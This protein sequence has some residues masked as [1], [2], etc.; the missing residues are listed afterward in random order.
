MKR[1]RSD[2]L[3]KTG[4]PSEPHRHQPSHSP[5]SIAMRKSAVP[6]NKCVVPN[7]SAERATITGSPKANGSGRSRPVQYCLDHYR[8][9]SDTVNGLEGLSSLVPIPLERKTSDMSDV[10]S[11]GGPLIGTPSMSPTTIAATLAFDFDSNTMS[12]HRSAS[13]ASDASGGDFHVSLHHNTGITPS[14][15]SVSEAFSSLLAAVDMAPAPSPIMSPATSPPTSRFGSLSSFGHPRLGGGKQFPSQLKN[16]G[17]PVFSPPLPRGRKRPDN[18]DVH[19]HLQRLNISGRKSPA[20]IDVELANTGI[21]GHRPIVQVNA[22]NGFP[23]GMQVEN[24]NGMKNGVVKATLVKNAS[25]SP[26]HIEAVQAKPVDLK[27]LDVNPDSIIRV[28]PTNMLTASGKSP[29]KQGGM[30]SGSSHTSPSKEE[31]DSYHDGQTELPR[32][33]TV[34]EHKAAK[35]KYKTYMSPDGKRFRS[36]LRARNYVQELEKQAAKEAAEAA[37]KGTPV[38]ATSSTG[39]TASAAFRVGG[40][41]HHTTQSNNSNNS[42][43]ETASDGQLGVFGGAATLATLSSEE[44]SNETTLFEH[45]VGFV[46]SAT[47]TDRKV[48]M[49][50]Y[51]P[52]HGETVVFTHPSCVSP[53]SASPAAPHP[54]ASLESLARIQS[55]LLSL[56]NTSS[57]SWRVPHV[58]ADR[59][60]IVG[61]HSEVYWQGLETIHALVSSRTFAQMPVDAPFNETVMYPS[62]MET[63]LYAAGAVV[64]AVDTVLTGRCRNAFVAV[65]PPGHLAEASRGKGFCLLNHIA[66][67]AHYAQ[68]VF[69]VNRIMIIDF[70]A[71]HGSGTENIV[72]ESSDVFYVSV[73]RSDTNIST[74]PEL[75]QNVQH[76]PVSSRS[77]FLASIPVVKQ[78][79]LDI[80]PELVLISAGFGGHK[81]DIQSENLQLEVSDFEDMT[82]AIVE[83]ADVRSDGRVVSLLEG[84]YNIQP[85]TECVR[86]HVGVLSSNSKN[87]KSEK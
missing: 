36:M 10:D 63:L 78:T 65:R 52:N 55:V 43:M 54:N 7:C 23:M 42:H 66:V 58:Q 29:S 26:L 35:S 79:I 30:S 1:V 80:C 39:N 73:H 69:H 49:K 71:H 22:N 41:H 15:P 6:V 34:I 48:R 18:D 64:S 59:Q 20:P 3:I 2:S 87:M 19:N 81:D 53:Q 17:N 86:A 21:S 13:I 33:W 75:A 74:R 45:L 27:D 40:E 44:L 38:K 83:A 56:S 61:C 84:G 57:I 11:S 12:R 77:E 46:E 82:E 28:T 50:Q 5:T 85:L 70:D 37:S 14:S 25:G 47:G 76:I 60:D 31:E 72:A 51:T 32:G 16:G 9:F 24:G 8:K 4:S 62:T 67:A 68:R